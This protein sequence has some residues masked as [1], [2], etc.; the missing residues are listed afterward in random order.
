M[1][2]KIRSSEVWM[3]TF[4]FHIL[5]NLFLV[6]KKIIKGSYKYFSYLSTLL[7]ALTKIQEAI[8]K[9]IQTKEIAEPA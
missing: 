9:A 2:L 3:G 4:F 6:K 1:L 8:K 7:L 5:L